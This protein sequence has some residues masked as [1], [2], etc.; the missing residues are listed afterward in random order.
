[1]KINTNTGKRKMGKDEPV[2][3]ITEMPDNNNQYFERTKKIIEENDNKIDQKALDDFV[4]FLGYTTPKKFW[5]I[6][7]KYCIN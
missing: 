6:V 7:E 2:F 5:G 4:K 1:M 3:I